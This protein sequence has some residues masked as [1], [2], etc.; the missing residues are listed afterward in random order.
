MLPCE[1]S[2]GLHCPSIFR[3]RL[4]RGGQGFPCDRIEY[5]GD[6]GRIHPPASRSPEDDDHQLR[7]IMAVPVAKSWSEEFRKRFGVDLIQV[8]GMTECNIV[9][10]TRT[11]G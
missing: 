4:V 10:F 7:R 1:W 5:A 8:Y 6:D 9:S 3:F 11:I 2:F